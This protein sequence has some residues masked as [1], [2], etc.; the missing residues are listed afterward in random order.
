MV[1]ASLDLSLSPRMIPRFFPMSAPPPVPQDD[2]A[3]ARIQRVAPGLR[4]VFANQVPEID[5][6]DDFEEEDLLDSDIGRDVID[7]DEEEIEPLVLPPPI[8]RHASPA[9]PSPALQAEQQRQWRMT[10]LCRQ[11]NGSVY[12]LRFSHL[13]TRRQFR[14]YQE[15]GA[16]FSYHWNAVRIAAQ[17]QHRGV[18]FRRISVAVPNTYSADQTLLH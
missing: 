6:D 4:I 3:L 18:R 1:S 9:P 11:V 7:S 15:N 12:N 17:L 5:S 14:I 13:R 16:V 10:R 8:V 2:G